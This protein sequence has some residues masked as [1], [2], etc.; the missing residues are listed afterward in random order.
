MKKGI[1]FSFIALITLTVFSQNTVYKYRVSFNDKAN[2]QYSLTNPA[3]FLSQKAITRRINQGILID[4]FDIPV[5]QNYIDSVIKY[6]AKF[7]NKSKWFNSIIVSL[8][9]TNIL[10]NINS[11]P[12]VK[13]TKLVIAVT[14]KKSKNKQNDE[15][16]KSTNI[17]FNPQYFQNFY[18][19]NE[20]DLVNEKEAVAHKNID[21]GQAYLQINM[22]QGT[23][24]HN[25]GYLGQGMTI[26]ILDA[27]FWH[28]DALNAFDSLW[29]NG[30]IIGTRDFVSPGSNVFNEATHG[31]MVLSTMG[32]NLPGQI[33]GTAPKANYWLVRTEDANSENLIEEDNWASGA[34]FA[35]SVGADLINSSLGYTNFDDPTMSHTYHELDG[36]TARATLAAT[37]AARK[38]IL[39]VNS[40]GNSG[41]SPWK[42]LGVP[43][44]ADSII[45]VGAVDT[46]KDYAS[47]SSI[48]PSYDGRVKPTVVALGQDAVFAS[49]SGVGVGNGTSFASP[50]LCGMASC[51]WQAFPQKSNQ[52]IIEAIKHSASQYYAPDYLLGY[53]IPN[54][55]I[56]SILLSG[57]A[58]HNFDNEN[59]F[60]AFP[61]PFDDILYIAYNSIDTQRV[62][63]ELFDLSGKKIMSVNDIP[64]HQGY[65]SITINDLFILKKG[66]YFIRITSGNITSIQKL[67]K[68]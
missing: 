15:T 25:Q 61:N 43:S 5:N 58:I 3:A 32:A 23:F 37:I 17:Y 38:G 13:N 7:I 67:M 46:N 65:N 68:K 31:M 18:T 21:Y 56:A 59:T 24:L 36:K 51:L 53:G 26:A 62:Q 10:Q 66:M 6:S 39:V 12:F 4:S 48:G 20:N 28:V 19:S 41:A 33:V 50:I 2:S 63:V 47:F 42:Y 64:R 14:S 35:D 57:N 1:L 52:D 40:M 45:S 8:T 22:L 54:F 11:L 30:Q 49:S 60:N 44:D 34:E 9:D 55:Q 27:G 16:V 29:L